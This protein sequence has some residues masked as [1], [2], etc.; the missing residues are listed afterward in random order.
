MELQSRYDALQSEGIGL[1]VI[2]YDDQN[3]IQAFTE[4]WGI[5][6]PVLS[7]VGSKVIKTYD[8]HNREVTPDTAF[9]D[10]RLY[11]IPYPGTFVVDRERHVVSRFFEKRYQERVTTA[12]MLRRSGALLSPFQA[13]SETSHISVTLSASDDI[14]APGNRFSLIVTVSPKSNMHVYA[15]GDH[16]YRIVR[17]SIDKPEF[18]RIHESVYPSSEIYYYE[19]LDES[20]PVYQQP[21]DLV[22]EVTIPMNDDVTKLASTPGESLIIEGTLEYQAC[23]DEVCYLP[24]QIPLSWN[25]SWRPL[26]Q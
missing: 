23:D 7:D 15:P 9:G 14:V 13:H 11:G 25:L 26:V 18:L 2:F 8:I 21:F 16:S 22:Q 20:V 17:L 5:Q 19:P 10:I 6:F 12:S 1:A 4:K 24:T 3:A